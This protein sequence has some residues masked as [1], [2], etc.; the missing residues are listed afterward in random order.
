LD[1]YD[2]MPRKLDCSS[3]VPYPYRR[4]DTRK[5][6]IYSCAML[7]SERVWWIRVLALRK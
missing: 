5:S 2:I 4:Q 6:G 1:K 3:F 7:C